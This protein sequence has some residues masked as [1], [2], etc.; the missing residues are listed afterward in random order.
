MDS[1]NPSKHPE[2]KENLINQ[3]ESLKFSIIS[4][5]EIKKK[6]SIDALDI[7]KNNDRLKIWGKLTDTNFTIKNN[8]L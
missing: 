1:N 2:T 3:I 7:Q 4:N 6:Y 8:L 5:E